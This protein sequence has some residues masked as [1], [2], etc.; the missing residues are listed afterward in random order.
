MPAS[1]AIAGRCSPAFVEPDFDGFPIGLRDL[2]PHYEAVAA[3]IGI[4]G[5]RDDLWPFLGELSAL[6]PAARIDD[7]GRTIHARYA[8]KRARTNAHGVYLGHPRVAM[9]TQPLR[10]R[11]PTRYFDMDFWSDAGKSV[12]RPR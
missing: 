6:Q 11:E 10:G 1:C 8:K 7:N 4:N 5:E 12:Y 3:R 9:L 2:V